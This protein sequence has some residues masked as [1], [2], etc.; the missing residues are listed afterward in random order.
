MVARFL[1]SQLSW[2][3]MPSCRLRTLGSEKVLAVKMTLVVA[4]GFV[5]GAPRLS[6]MVFTKRSESVWP[7][8]SE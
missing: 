4:A 6:W 7:N 5:P 1:M 3:K 8:C 2:M